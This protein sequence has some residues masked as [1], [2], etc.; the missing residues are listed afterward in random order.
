MAASRYTVRIMDDAE[1][2]LKKIQKHDRKRI[3]EKIEALEV[4]PRPRGVKKIRGMEKL[5]RIRVGDYRVV[6]LIQ[7]DVLLVLVIIVA[8]RKDAY[9]NL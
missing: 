1:R 8:R 2:Q 5:Y 4:D 6:Y 7:D 3:T 9:R